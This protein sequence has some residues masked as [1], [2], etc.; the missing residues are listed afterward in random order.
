MSQNG[1][2]HVVMYHDPF[3]DPPVIGPTSLDGGW[4]SLGLVTRTLFMTTRSG[5]QYKAT[6]SPTLAQAGV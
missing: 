2:K 3:Q 5:S 4:E 6:R 1:D